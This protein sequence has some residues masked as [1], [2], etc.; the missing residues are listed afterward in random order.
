MA[1]IYI[2]IL[3]DIMKEQTNG[4]KKIAYYLM[5]TISV[6]LIAAAMVLTIYFLSDKDN[7]LENPP[8]D[9]PSV[10]N[11]DNPDDTNNPND[12]PTG[13]PDDPNNPDIP[14]NPTPTAPRFIAPLEYD[15]LSTSHKDIYAN[16]TTGTYYRHHGIDISAEAGAAVKCVAQGV[17]TEISMSEQT[18]NYITVD[19]GDVVSLYRFVEPTA[20]LK[21]GDSVS[22]GQQIATVAEA[23]GA[24]YK[25]GAHLHLEMIENGTQ[26]DPVDYLEPVNEEK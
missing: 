21:V 1:I 5:L 26:V 25:D 22:Q 9:G 11:P 6:L 17:I 15:E 18:G 24:E 13:N 3:E 7:T 8:V 23:Y 10:E 20:G 12:T 19:H 2:E 14:D 16:L 4:K